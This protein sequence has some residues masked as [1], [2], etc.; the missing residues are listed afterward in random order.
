MSSND[1]TQ[2][3]SL[4][5]D[6]CDRVNGAKLLTTMALGEEDGGWCGRRR[7]TTLAIGEEGDGPGPVALDAALHLSK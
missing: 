6:D 5:D 4:S 7:F 1:E 2:M 3:R